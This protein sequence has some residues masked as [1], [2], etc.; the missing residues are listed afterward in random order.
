MRAA[1]LSASLSPLLV[2]K[3]AVLAICT[4]CK[5]PAAAAPKDKEGPAKV[6]HVASEGELN[7]I[8][9]TAEAEQHLGLA[10]AAVES[11][12]MP[13]MNTYGGEIMVPPG[14]SIVVSA[15]FTGTLQEPAKNAVPAAGSLVDAKQPVFKFQP[16]VAPE[17]EAL[18]PA[19]RV[20]YAEARNAIAT[21]RIDA[22]A[23][24]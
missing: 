17:R 1:F 9:L 19:E 5:P 7:T 24:L 16:L 20:R 3:L 15:P 11:R 4:G 10:L 14:A 22:T 12:A 2:A 23:A 21:A 8:K 6:A 18:T 13:R